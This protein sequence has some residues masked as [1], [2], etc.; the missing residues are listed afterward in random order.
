MLRRA[1]PGIVLLVGLAMP[2][3]SA[4]ATFHLEKVNE[5]MLASASG[6]STVQFVELLD[7]GGAE[8][9][10]PPVFAPYK[11][12]VYDG[13]GK[14]LGEQTLNPTGLRNAAAAGT[15][16]LIATPA[17]ASAFGVSADEPL[18]VTLPLDTAQ[19][20]Y[21]G[22][23][24]NI[25]CIAYGSVTQPVPINSQGSGSAMGPVPPNGESDQRQGDDSVQAAPPTPKAA[26]RA[27]TGLPPAPPAG[28]SNPPGSMSPSFAGVR[29][30]AHVA[31]VDRHGRA[32][33]SLSCPTGTSGKCTGHIVLSSGRRHVSVGR[34]AFALAS[35]GHG[36]IQVKL[37]A[38]ARRTLARHSRLTVRAS[39]VASDAAGH[40]RT[41]ASQ[42]TLKR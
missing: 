9:A 34:A 25:S 42:L 3:T 10:F 27:G 35:G 4:Q 12:V 26:N 15:E 28:P 13:A 21:R 11:L 5:V 19:V 6:D 23:P 18:T 40:D 36:V 14:E 30:R 29:V 37:S 31:K 7:K 2:V 16:Y 20:C 33:V 41:I 1:I 22:S 17:A 38:T 24:G 39:V 8:E 32:L